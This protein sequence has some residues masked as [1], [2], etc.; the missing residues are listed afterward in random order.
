MASVFNSGGGPS[1]SIYDYGGA[2][3]STPSLTYYERKFGGGGGDG[4]EGQSDFDPSAFAPTY[5]PTDKGET[6]IRRP[7]GLIFFIP[8][9]RKKQTSM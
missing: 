1:S 8:M 2:G 7:M 6:E 4:D 3:S 5:T 9:R